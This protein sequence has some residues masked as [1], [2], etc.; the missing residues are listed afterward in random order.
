[1]PQPTQSYSINHNTLTTEYII[2]ITNA[3]GIKT[4]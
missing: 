2:Q 4:Y 1:M 3:N